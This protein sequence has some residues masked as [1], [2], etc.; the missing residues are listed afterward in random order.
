MSITWWIC[1]QRKNNLYNRQRYPE[2]KH[3][4][5]IQRGWHQRLLDLFEVAREE[6][7]RPMVTCMESRT[8]NRLNRMMFGYC[9]EDYVTGPIRTKEN[10]SNKYH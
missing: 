10:R 6:C 7:L 2:E 9:R 3:I 5:E 1:S 4:E 8:V